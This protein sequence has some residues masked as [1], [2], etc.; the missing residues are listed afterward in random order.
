[1][2]YATLTGVL[3][4]LARNR[5]ASRHSGRKS[6]A[7]LRD[8]PP[9]EEEDPES[10]GAVQCVQDQ[11]Q[12]RGHEADRRKVRPTST[13]R[14]LHW[15]RLLARVREQEQVRA[16]GN[17][18]QSGCG[19]RQ[20]KQGDRPVRPVLSP[21]RLLRALRHTDR[22]GLGAQLGQTAL[23]CAAGYGAK[24]SVALLLA[25]GAKMVADVE[26]QTPLDLAT[27]YRQ[28]EVVEMLSP[29]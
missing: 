1:M 8:G 9:V 15:R 21:P 22:C 3:R 2:A 20:T 29:T 12:G 14:P 7:G 28:A 19:R 23:H 25:H 5:L 18:A 16:D 4:F 11:Q 13:C 27:N 26:G 6:S 24:E 17:S 10:G